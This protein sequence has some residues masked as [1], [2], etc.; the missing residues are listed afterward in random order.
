MAPRDVPKNVCAH[1]VLEKLQLSHGIYSPETL[2]YLMGYII[3]ITV[4]MSCLFILVDSG[5]F[6]QISRAMVNLVLVEYCRSLYKRS[7]HEQIKKHVN[8]TTFA[9][10]KPSMAIAQI[11]E[12]VSLDKYKDLHKAVTAKSRTLDHAEG[13]ITTEKI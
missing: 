4:V 2:R 7:I 1:H 5:G 6:V 12:L 3:D 8:N 9:G 11:T 13:W 10:L